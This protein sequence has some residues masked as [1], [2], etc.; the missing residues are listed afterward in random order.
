LNKIT[1]GR[2][3]LFRFSDKTALK[4][5]TCLISR[6]VKM[7]KLIVSMGPA[8]NKLARNTKLRRKPKKLHS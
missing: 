3:T 2:K 7:T 1:F 5:P 8:I 6:K 4:G